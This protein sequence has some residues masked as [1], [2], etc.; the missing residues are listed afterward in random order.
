MES[1]RIDL[2]SEKQKCKRLQEQVEKDVAIGEEKLRNEILGRKQDE[3]DQAVEE[4][5]K[6]NELEFQSRMAEAIQEERAKG[7]NKLQE[8]LEKG[9]YLSSKILKYHYESMVIF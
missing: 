2:A 6:R 3:I 4:E 1:T 5:R 8:G 9:L 7:D